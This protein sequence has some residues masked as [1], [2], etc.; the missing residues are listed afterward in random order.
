MGV[1][2]I[3]VPDS[4]EA[5]F[6]VMFGRWLAEPPVGGTTSV[7]QSQAEGEWVKESGLTKRLWE[8]AHHAAQAQS[9]LLSITSKVHALPT[10]FLNDPE[11]PRT[12][13]ELTRSTGWAPATLHSYRRLLG[14]QAW[15]AGKFVNPITSTR[16]GG[17]RVY[18]MRPA[19]AEAIKA[20]GV[21]GIS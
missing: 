3:N 13:D 17:V 21:L 6:H 15:R 5:N 12:L 14:K 16:K 11:E 20:S 10:L 18:Y 2:Q 9:M 7:N 4:R 1:L 8:G 19:T